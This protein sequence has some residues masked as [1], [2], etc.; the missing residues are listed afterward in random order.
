MA[1]KGAKAFLGDA[2]GKLLFREVAVTELVEV[3]PSF[4]K[5]TLAGAELRGASFSAGDKV[6]VMLPEVGSRT[7][8]P[9][10]FDRVEGAMQFLTFLHGDEPGAR[11]ARGA[12][13]GDRIRVFGPRG[14]LPLASLDGALVIFGDETSFGV[15]RAASEAR[16]TSGASGASGASAC[17]FEVSAGDAA[18]VAVEALGLDKAVLVEKTGTGSHLA[19][20]EA[21]LREALG[22]SPRAHLV[23]TGKAQSIQ[24][25]RA[26]FKA[27]PAP[28]AGQKV[29]AYWSV[30]KRGLD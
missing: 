12:K 25:L 11:W 3:A 15:A 1:F 24:V 30:G 19:A 10:A 17:V 14:S 20:V 27:R 8:T 2:L 6:Q 28:C 13:V 5:M 26:A 16:G 23:L 4:R 21:R 7:Y 29:K 9:F 22:E 18:K